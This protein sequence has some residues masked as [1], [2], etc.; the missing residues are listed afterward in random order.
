M[1]AG[2]DLEEAIRQAE[3]HLETIRRL[4]QRR[5]LPPLPQSQAVPNPSKDAELDIKKM[6]VEVLRQQIE[7]HGFTHIKLGRMVGIANSDISDLLRGQSY[8]RFSVDRINR[9]LSAFGVR[10]ETSYQLKAIP[11]EPGLPMDPSTPMR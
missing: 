6:A 7:E 10:I 3:R 9:I 4:S 8:H 1:N 11:Q 5:P 2:N